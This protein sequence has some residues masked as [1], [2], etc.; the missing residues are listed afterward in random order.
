MAPNTVLVSKK[1]DV[2]S[3]SKTNV[4]K[5]HAEDAF[6]INSLDKQVNNQY[7]KSS[8]AP[9]IVYIYDT[10]P[11]NNLGN[12]HPELI[13]KIIFDANV[14]IIGISS[15]GTKNFSINFQTYQ[16]ANKFGKE[17]ISRVC[18]HWKAFIPDQALYKSGIMI[19][20][21]PSLSNEEILK[22]LD[23]ESKK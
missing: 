6:D 13:G 18:S 8:K 15:V 21:A 4:L 14:E 7:N 5:S 22:G 11:G 2:G 3:L 17:D 12:A 1:G 23:A 9:F 16:Q 10:S 20:I 19:N